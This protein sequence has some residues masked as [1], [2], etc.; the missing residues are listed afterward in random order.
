MERLHHHL[1]EREELLS[2]ANAQGFKPAHES[3]PAFFEVWRTPKAS[4]RLTRVSRLFLSSRPKAGRDSVERCLP[5]E[6]ARAQQAL[7]GSR[8]RRSL[9]PPY[10]TASKHFTA[11]PS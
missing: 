5:A 2:L 4:S 6:P 11:V 9:A 10:E 8:V 1:L 3:E 7:T